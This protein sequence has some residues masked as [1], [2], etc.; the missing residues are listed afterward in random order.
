MSSLM[1]FNED[2][3]SNQYKS[4][5]SSIVPGEGTMWNEATSYVNNHV[6]RVNINN[7]NTNTI[8][9]IPL[10]KPKALKHSKPVKS[11]KKK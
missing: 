4:S 10:A 3:M 8:V 5:F 2:Q 6:P 11:R 9:G 7:D 1:I